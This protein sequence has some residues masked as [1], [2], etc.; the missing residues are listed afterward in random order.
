MDDKDESGKVKKSA[1][2]TAGRWNEL[3]KISREVGLPSDARGI[4]FLAEIGLD[5]YYHQDE[6]PAYKAMVERVRDAIIE[7][8][9]D[10]NTTRNEN[11]LRTMEENKDKPGKR[12][13]SRPMVV[14]ERPETT[15][16]GTKK[17]ASRSKK[18][19]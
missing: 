19:K 4:N 12:H 9:R 10:S 15:P 2:F 17:P 13:G 6:N 14:S 5:V 16:A 3:S 11:R 18:V 1:Y 8:V 7:E